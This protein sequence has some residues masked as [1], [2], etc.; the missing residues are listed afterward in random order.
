MT[1]VSNPTRSHQAGS[2]SHSE[3]GNLCSVLRGVM[4]QSLDQNF[5]IPPAA[6][7]GVREHRINA[8]DAHRAM[9]EGPR[10]HTLS[11][12]CE[13]RV[14]VRECEPPLMIAAP[15]GPHLR[16]VKS[17]ARGA[18]QPSIPRR[19]LFVKNPVEEHAFGRHVK[20]ASGHRRPMCQRPS[21]GNSLRLDSLYWCV[22]LQYVDQM[23][24]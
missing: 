1:S 16:R 14:I 4:E 10:H 24:A 17:T 21:C 3:D 13:H 23:T 6:V 2:M 11:R 12:A 20:D 8:A 19:A 22:G 9:I 7:R 18:A 15:G 5:R